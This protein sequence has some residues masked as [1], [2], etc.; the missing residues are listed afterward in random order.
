MVENKRGKGN[1][2]EGTSILKIIWPSEI[3]SPFCFFL[4]MGERQQNLMEDPVGKQQVHLVEQGTWTSGIIRVA[5]SM[6]GIISLANRMSGIIS[7]ASKIS[8]ISSL[9]NKSTLILVSHLKESSHWLSHVIA[10][11]K[12]NWLPSEI[13]LK[14]P[15]KRHF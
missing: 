1:L 10:T 9:A 5:I 2:S 7:V 11:Q 4:Q 8:G 6:S 14:K 15:K 3:S 13:N 12:P